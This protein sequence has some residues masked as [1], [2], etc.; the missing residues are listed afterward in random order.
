MCVRN[1]ATAQERKTKGNSLESSLSS[2]PVGSVDEV[3][4]IR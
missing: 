4:V 2:H 3:Q 1:P